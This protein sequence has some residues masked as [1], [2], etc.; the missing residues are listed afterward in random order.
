[1]DVVFED[2]NEQESSLEE[3]FLIEDKAPTSV[4]GKIKSKFWK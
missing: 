1:M 3:N 2:G 4:W